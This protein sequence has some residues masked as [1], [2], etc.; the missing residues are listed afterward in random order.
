MYIVIV[1]ESSSLLELFL[2][3]CPA[4]T[5]QISLP[6]LLLAFLFSL[7]SSTFFEFFFAPF[8]NRSNLLLKSFGNVT[9]SKDF[10]LNAFADMVID[11][12]LGLWA[13]VTV[14]FV[15]S[16]MLLNKQISLIWTRASPV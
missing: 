7:F 14:P 8:A 3:F 13:I 16:S 1:V 12:L 5:S 6:C 4:L 11:E 9:L 2:F 15:A 10:H